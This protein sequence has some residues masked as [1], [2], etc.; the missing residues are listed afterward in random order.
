MRAIVT[1]R[2][3][4]L[5]MAGTR[6]YAERA[7]PKNHDRGMEEVGLTG[8]GAQLSNTQ[9]LE[10]EL[11]AAPSDSGTKMSEEPIEVEMGETEQL[12]SGIREPSQSDYPELS[13]GAKSK[14]RTRSRSPMKQEENLP[15]MLFLK[16]S[17]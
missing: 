3:P 15:G 13:N 1:V 7:N 17:E 10:N 11:S 6:T 9:L 4:T 2:Q 8:L 14:D 12:E 16:T 5:N